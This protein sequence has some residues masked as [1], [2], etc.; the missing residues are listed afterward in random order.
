VSDSAKLSIMSKNEGIEPV[1][2]AFRRGIVIV[3]AVA[4]AVNGKAAPLRMSLRSLVVVQHA[5]VRATLRLC[6]REARAIA[7]D[8]ITIHHQP[9]KYSPNLVKSPS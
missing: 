7:K 5:D 1:V 2:M 8:E 9:L 4:C 3:G 6:E